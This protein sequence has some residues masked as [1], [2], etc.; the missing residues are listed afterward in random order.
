MRICLNGDLELG[1]ILWVAMGELEVSRLFTIKP[2]F[3]ADLKVILRADS[4]FLTSSSANFG[5]I[6]SSSTY[7]IA[8]TYS[9]L[10][11]F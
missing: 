2:G 6:Y 3:L 7:F 1:E 11:E 10:I 5:F 4:S 8:L 9:E